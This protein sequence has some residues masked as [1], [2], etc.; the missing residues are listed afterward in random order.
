MLEPLLV[1]QLMKTF[2]VVYSR[3][4]APLQCLSENSRVNDVGLLTYGDFAV[5]VVVARS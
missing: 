5:S 3:C 1:G 4:L 2:S